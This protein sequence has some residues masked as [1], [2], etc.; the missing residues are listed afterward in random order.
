[1]VEL[2]HDQGLA[3]ADLAEQAR[4]RR[5]G[6]I[7]AGGRVFLAYRV[8]VGGAQLVGLRIGALFFGRDPRVADHTTCGACRS[9]VCAHSAVAF[10]IGRESISIGLND[11]ICPHWC[12]NDAIAP[13]KVRHWA[14]KFGFDMEV[15]LGMQ[16]QTLMDAPEAV[17]R[18]AT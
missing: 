12:G 7:G 13:E 1:V 14:G 4:Q 18:K 10:R 5:P 3:G 2:D 11:F 15:I 8:A 16:P 6:A 9:A 17:W